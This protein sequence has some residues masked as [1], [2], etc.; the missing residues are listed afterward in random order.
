MI[1]VNF[2]TVSRDRAT[3]ANQPLYLEG[4]TL[5]PPATGSTGWTLALLFMAPI[6][7]GAGLLTMRD[8]AAKTVFSESIEN[9]SHMTISGNK[10]VIVLGAALAYSAYFAISV[11]AGFVKDVAGI[12]S[13]STN[14]SVETLPSPFPITLVGTAG[15]DNLRGG[16]ANDQLSGLG[17]NDKLAGYLGSDVLDGGDGDDWLYVYDGNDTLRGGDGNDEL[18]AGWSGPA[19]LGPSLLEAGAGDDVLFSGGA[20][21]TVEGGTGNDAIYVWAAY[22][23]GQPIEARGGDGDDNIIAYLEGAGRVNARGGAGV[24]TFSLQVNPFG[25]LYVSDFVAGA[26]G[27]KLNLIM[28]MGDKLE[29]GNPFGALGYLRMQQQGSDTVVQLDED[30]AAGSLNDFTTIMTLAG[31][32]AARITQDNIAAGLKLSGAEGGLVTSGTAG[33]DY[34]VGDALGDHL[35][36]EDG[37]DVLDGGAGNDMLQGGAGDDTVNGDAGNDL[38]FGGTGIDKLD[39]NYG[40]DY[41]DGGDDGDTLSDS[42]GNNTM[43][44]GEGNDFLISRGTGA[45][46]LAGGNGNDTLISQYGNDTLSGGAGA[47]NIVIDR[48]ARAADSLAPHAFVIDGGDGADTINVRW[49]PDH[50]LSVRATGGA[51]R[52][53]YLMDDPLRTGE[54]VITDFAPGSAGDVLFIGTLLGGGKGDPFDPVLGKL[55]LLQRAADT[56]LQYRD[57][58]LF[59]DLVVLEGVSKT[60]LTEA[61]FVRLFLPSTT[62]NELVLTGGQGDDVLSAADA[63]DVLSGGGGNDTLY[64]LGG[65]DTLNGGDGNDLLVGG[66]GA[67]MLTGGAGIDTARYGW[68]QN[69][70]FWRENDGWHVEQN[71]TFFFSSDS[72][73]VLTG[74]ER[75]HF[76][77]V[78]YALDIDGTGGMVYRLYQAA[79]DRTPD[80]VGVGFWM[81]KVD[82]GLPMAQVLDFFV[83]SPEF[84]TLYGVSPSNAALVSRFYANMLHREPDAVGKAFWIDMLDTHKASVAEVLSNFAESPENQAAVA[85]V[86]GNGFQYQPYI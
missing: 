51:G 11:P 9:N 45:N 76:N 44:G 86:I 13:S 16:D 2:I 61:N 77:D 8:E 80:K 67:N 37:N 46:F 25:M 63:D 42:Y 35:R 21:D 32:S 54:Y 60:S 26:G 22:N 18:S 84:A 81:A 72:S 23:A 66:S 36:G 4:A 20:G 1:P 69:T 33:N 71:G 24:D 30:G 29:Q 31:V 82:Q 7:A 3:R 12:S 19:S 39:G 47:D 79:F 49:H 52:D 41:L 50:P 75:L 57:G 40:D 56:V 68:A 43:L 64:G 53:I 6:V 14:I 73:D 83:H 65:N 34:L 59:I 28:L 48:T 62:G 74:V 70:A 85:V 58:S 15:M 10:V 27:D 78:A 55:Q 17:G 38:L 5:L